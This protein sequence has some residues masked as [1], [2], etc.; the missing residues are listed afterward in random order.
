MERVAEQRKPDE[1]RWG[2]IPSILLHILFFAALFSRKLGPYFQ[3]ID[4]QPL[5]T[6]IDYLFRRTGCSLAKRGREARDLSNERPAGTVSHRKA[7]LA[8]CY[9]SL[10]FD[11]GC[12]RRR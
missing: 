5:T 4:Y 3:L 8:F 10:I 11:V 7:L 6:V 2:L 1:R 9:L 12:W